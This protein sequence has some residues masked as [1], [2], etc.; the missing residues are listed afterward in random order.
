IYV[1]WDKNGIFNSTDERVF[2]QA[3]AVN[4]VNV[5]SGNFT[6]P[7][8]ASL[9]VTRMRVVLNETTT[10][11]TNWAQTAYSWGETEDYCFT[12][13][14]SSACSGLPTPGNTT[15]PAIMCTGASFTLGL[16]NIITG[17]GVSY[18]WQTSPDG[19]T[20]TNATGASTN[21]TYTTSETA[22]TYY[23]AQVTCA[24]NGTAASTPI[25]VVV[26][27]NACECG[28]YAAIY[29]SSTADEDITVV[30]VG[31]MTNNS[32]CGALAPGAGS[33]AGRYSNYTGSVTGPTAMQGAS[34]PFSVGQGTLCGGAYSNVVQI[35]VD[36][37]KNGIFNDTDERVFA[38]AAA[39]NGVNVQ[40]GNFMVPAGASLGVTRMR[41]VLNETTTTATNW[42]QTAYSWGETEDYCFTVTASSACSGLPTPGNTTGPASICSGTSFTLGL[43]NIITGSGVSY[44]WET[45]PDGSTWT[46][47]AGASSNS[48]YTTSQTSTTYYRAQVTCAGNGTTASTPITI[49]I[50]PSACECGAYAA[51]YTTY[52]G[53][54]DITV[55][56]VGSMTNNSS[57]D[58]LA[59]GAGSIASR[60]SNYTGII[61][62]PSAMQGASVPFNVG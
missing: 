59:P 49:A 9:G 44:Q 57:C 26:N 47:A 1:D 17:S 7:A 38:Q 55:V 50:N 3:A 45:S 28:T 30:T 14:A 18:Q 16:Q 41:V 52:T 43:Q 2:A 51:N 15:G 61:A 37:D 48:T 10:T 54:E 24:G 12:V 29:A 56:T 25:T 21:S 60:Y 36:W 32:A 27:T 35:Y 58:A 8:G 33:L 13:T 31:S 46:N 5:Q 6:V 4:G 39:V 11:A 40:S 23:R 62:G 34:V 19:S 53:D 42:A 20:W 22:T